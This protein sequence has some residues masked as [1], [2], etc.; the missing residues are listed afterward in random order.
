MGFRGREE[1]G[2][3]WGGGRAATDVTVASGEAVVMTYAPTGVT[4][5]KP[6]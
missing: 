5:F 2:G 6:R 4:V 1:G 3:G